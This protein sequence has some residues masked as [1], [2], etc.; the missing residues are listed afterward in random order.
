MSGK[1]VLSRPRPDGGSRSLFRAE[2]V[3]RRGLAFS[4]F[5]R[6][7]GVELLRHVLAPRLRARIDG[8]SLRDEVEPGWRRG[9]R[10]GLLARFEAGAVGRGRDTGSDAEGE[11]VRGVS[12][13]CSVLIDDGH[14]A[15]VESRSPKGQR[16][17]KGS[18][19]ARR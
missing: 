5:L 1:L 14:P 16:A 9:A 15:V 6:G 10:L 3:K 18:L 2:V 17:P 8:A 13:G 11:A 19:F 7:C 12:A 4:L